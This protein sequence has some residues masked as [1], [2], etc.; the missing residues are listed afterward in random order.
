[1]KLL[2]SLT[3]WI[4]AGFV[5]GVLFGYLFRESILPVANPAAAIFI[6]SLK[7][8]VMPI[9][10]FSIA[11]GILNIESGKE[12]RKLGVKTFLYYVTTTTLA[13]ITGQILVTLV[14][15]G[16][17]VTNLVS[18]NVENIPAAEGS[19]LDILIDIIP[20]N[21]ISAMAEGNV[22]QVIFF[23]I[24][25]SLIIMRFQ[26]KYRTFYND[27]FQGGFNIMM[28][29]V[30][31]IIWLA[32]VGV[33]GIVAG[34]VAE[35]GFDA[36]IG[37][38]K[39]FFT[40]LGGLLFHA[41]VT[42]PVI[43]SMF[44]GMNPWLHFKNMLLA[45]ETA[46]FTSSSMATLPITMECVINND[47]VEPKVAN[48]VLPIGATVNMDGTAL[49]EAVAVIFIAQAYGIELTFIQLIIVLLTTVLASIGAAAIPMAG[50]VMITIILKAVGLPLEGVGL[51]LAVDRLLDMVRTT[52][53]VWS[54]SCGAVVVNNLSRK[55]T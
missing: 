8:I 31:W 34:I 23:M 27:F 45:I 18:A 6:N 51:V 5:F 7:M 32:P 48:F 49:Y 54:D 50:F 3:F 12:L 39:Y 14:K 29:M 24:L 4:F 9:I 20:T 35:T 41:F 17:N 33:F 26:D 25:F 40:V 11:S 10:I 42:L 28:E 36:I 52:V 13:I 16:S 19:I 38:M 44:G 46:F 55:E 2:K 21:P 22:I 37:L 1:M 53:N 15:P 30:R 47:K 43:L